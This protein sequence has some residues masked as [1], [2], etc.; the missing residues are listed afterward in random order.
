MKIAIVGSAGY[1]AG[2]L[3]DRFEADP[4]VESILKID[5]TD[6]AD[7]WLD[8]AEAERFDYSVLEGIDYVVLTAAISSPDKCAAEYAL[9]WQINVTGTACF[10]REAL[11]RGCRVLFFSS[12]AVFGDIPGMIYDENSPTQPNTPYGRMKKAIED[13]F[14]TEPRFKAIR[15]SY[16]AS[17]RDRFVS[18]CRS[19]IESGETADVFHPFYR[20]VIIVDDVVDVV[21]WFAKHWEEYPH[22]VLDVAGAELVSRVRIADELNRI[23]GGALRYGISH[24]GAA[25][26]ANRPAI[27]QMRSLFLEQYRIL[28]SESFTEKIQRTMEVVTHE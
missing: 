7:V 6:D 8:L 22:F 26:Y 16:V 1:I 27:T 20:N 28:P 12:D 13:E 9:C 15:L 23:C 3:I 21:V 25:F 11:R 24:P 19:C 14:R 4:G 10:I 2:F 18:Y 5:R 17:Y